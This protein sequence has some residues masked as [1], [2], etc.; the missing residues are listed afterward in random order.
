MSQI[1]ISSIII[2]F[3]FSGQKKYD[4]KHLNMIYVNTSDQQQNDIITLFGQ[5][6]GNV[7]AKLCFPDK[8]VF[9]S[10]IFA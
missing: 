3:A 10:N 5:L 4:E 1:R 2:S 6:H 9:I 8:N 7:M